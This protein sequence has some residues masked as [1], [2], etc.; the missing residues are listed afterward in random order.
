MA[1]NDIVMGA[2]GASGPAT[3][4]EDVFST[5]LF[6]TD[7]G[8]GSTT[9]NNGIDLSGKG[10]LVWIKQ[11]NAAS[12]HR[13]SDTARGAGLLAS[14]TTD[15]Q[16]VPGSPLTFNNN[17]F[18]QP[19]TLAYPQPHVSWTFREQP[20][21]FDIV[22]W[23]GDGSFPRVINHS[24]GS[25][26]GCIII[27]KTSASDNWYVYHRSLTAGYKVQLDSTGA[28]ASAGGYITSVTDT[29][30]SPAYNDSGSTYVA[31][32]FAHNAGGFGATGTD[33]VVSCGS[34][35]TDGSG[36]GSV[37]LGYEPQWVLMKRTDDASQWY[38]A[39]NMRGMPVSGNGARLFPNLSNAESTSTSWIR[40]NATGFTI[41]PGM[42]GGTVNL[43]YIAIRRPMK[44]PTTGTSVFSPQT[45]TSTDV[46]PRTI[47]T[48]FATDMVL[49]KPIT[50]N[51]GMDYKWRLADRLKGV[52]VVGTNS[53]SE[54]STNDTNSENYTNSVTTYNSSFQSL[55]SMTGVTIGYLLNRTDD[56]GNVNYVGYNFKRAAG[57]FDVVCFTP[58]GAAHTEP[59]NLGVAPELIIGKS[60]SDP[61]NWYVYAAPLGNTQALYF[62]TT[63]TPITGTYLWNNTSP[64]ST[65]FSL[66]A[67][68]LNTSASTAAVAYLFATVA[69]VSKVGSY[70]G[71]GSSQTINCGFTTGARFI[72]IKCTSATGDWKVIDSARGI[73]AG[74]D[75]T[76]A[77]N[78]TAAEVTGT[79]CIDP[80]SSGFIVNQ[81]TTNNLN[82]NGASYIF[83]SI[84]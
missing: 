61:F 27:K 82:V 17:G 33:N 35:T 55:A 16:F 54:L 9:V 13:L 21:F 47:T 66:G 37:T 29:S 1:V 2:A 60:R 46:E 19:G 20:K 6:T 73:V 31:Y 4:V 18:T 14:N 43:I 23:T 15:A 65:T 71:N 7:A 64:T 57:F 78:T 67:S 81:E 26:P 42:F 36:N 70:T 56:G 28:Q 80:D 3:F 22:T 68:G 24:L 69:G 51:G 62:N 48:G 75:P 38:L 32:L 11:R 39:D 12:D 74:N 50:S 34:F 52:G 10:G 41:D 63:D 59:H 5:Y 72:M 8:G 79:D 58:T 84:S 76:L 30:F 83:L 44:T 25:T 77:L 53:G 40:P 49:Y 45:W